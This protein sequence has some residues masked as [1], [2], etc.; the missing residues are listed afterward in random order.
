MRFSQ[1]RFEGAKCLHLR[2]QAADSANTLDDL[3]I[4]Q[5]PCKNLK[6]RLVDNYQ[7]FGVAYCPHIQTV[8]VQ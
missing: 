4:H 8:A 6:S 7:R 3:N 5:R 2:D 1:Q